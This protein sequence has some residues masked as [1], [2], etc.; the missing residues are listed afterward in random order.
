MLLRV[1]SQRK[2]RDNS[3]TEAEKAQHLLL[4][5]TSQKKQ[6]D[7]SITEAEKAQHLLIRDTSQKKQREE[8]LA[9]Q[10]HVP[11]TVGQVNIALSQSMV[12]SGI[13]IGIK[14]TYEGSNI[15]VSFADKRVI[16]G[17][18][19]EMIVWRAAWISCATVV[20]PRWSHSRRRIRVVR[21]DYVIP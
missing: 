18:K 1:T 3:V 12:P 10:P 8:R 7:N 20:P 14:H 15:H 5:V 4:R 16:N 11:P 2:Q 9:L 6:R 13:Y 21:Q 19:T 17:E